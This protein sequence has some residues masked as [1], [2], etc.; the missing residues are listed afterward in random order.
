MEKEFEEIREAVNKN[1][2]WIKSTELKYKALHR[3]QMLMDKFD[4][5]YLP[6]TLSKIQTMARAVGCFAT[7]Y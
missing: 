2:T 5:P 1:L 4:M 3:Q 6:D 7:K